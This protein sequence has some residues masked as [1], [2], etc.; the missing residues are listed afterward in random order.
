MGEDEQPWPAGIEDHWLQRGENLRP[1]ENMPGLSTVNIVIP[2]IRFV[3]QLIEVLKTRIIT[4]DV[5]E[6]YDSYFQSM[7]HHVPE[8]LSL[9]SDGWLD[10]FVFSS[11]VPLLMVQ[12]QL[13]RHNLN[14]YATA[15]ERQ[16][17]LFRCHQ[18]G[19]QTV[20]FLNRVMRNPPHPIETTFPGASRG[21][22][23][24]QPR[25]NKVVHNMVCRHTWRCTLIFCLRGDFDSALTCVEFSKAIGDVRKLNIACGR[26]LAFF[27]DQLLERTSRGTPQR[28]I[29]ADLELIA[30]ASGDLQ[31]SQDGFVWTGVKPSQQNPSNAFTA[32]SVRMLVDDSPPSALLTD[33]EIH[34]WGGWAKVEEKIGRLIS[35]QRR[36]Q[37]GPHGYAPGPHAQSPAYHRSAHNEMKRVQLGPPEHAPS[38]AAELT[39]G[40]SSSRNSPPTGASRISIANII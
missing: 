27:L 7:S 26:N 22:D 35:E 19:M 23:T 31:G 38:P 12:F 18:V 4:R 29:E 13:Y 11:I 10:P 6:Q 37:Q 2:V 21:Q 5:L 36:R 40:A 17:A 14:G 30:Y 24:W 15:Q 9:N 34:D 28:D 32:A 20:K 25:L 8:Q 3:G 33:A 1:P 39:T 16:E